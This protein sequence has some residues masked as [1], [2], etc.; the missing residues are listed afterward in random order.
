MDQVWL[1]L[2]LMA[3]KQGKTVFSL[4]PFAPEELVSR[5]GFGRPVLRQPAHSLRAGRL[6]LVLSHGN[7]AAFHEGFHIYTANR[8]GVSLKFIGS[9]YCMVMLFTAKSPLAMLCL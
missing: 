1:P 9:R 8:Y 4:S 2:L 3:E 5:D 7:R 6:N